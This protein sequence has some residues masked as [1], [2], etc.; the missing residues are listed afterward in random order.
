[1][2]DLFLNNKYTKWYYSIINNAAVNQPE[3]NVYSE[4]HH[5][6][7]K[8]LGGTNNSDNLIKLTAREHFICHLLLTK[9]IS[10]ADKYKMYSAFWRMLN[11]TKKQ[12]DLYMSNNKWYEITRKNVSIHISNLFKGKKHSPETIKKLKNKI[13]WNKGLTKDTDDRV[14]KNSINANVVRQS[15]SDAT[16]QKISN[17]VK[18][19]YHKRQIKNPY[20]YTKGLPRIKW[21]IK[22]ESTNEIVE[23]TNLRQWCKEQG[24]NTNTFYMKRKCKWNI[25]SK[26]RIKTGE[27]LPF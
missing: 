22:N 6:I 24:L 27:I 15:L 19:N 11:S 3:R 16:K 17:S 4:I 5:I 23:T 26:I 8:S 2:S 14:L 18:N 7:P 10:G 20:D 13:P 9:M 21:I 25:V 1:M 12:S